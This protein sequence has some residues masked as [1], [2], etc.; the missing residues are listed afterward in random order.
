[1][2]EPKPGPMQ[3][4]RVVDL[5][6]ALSG[7][8]A[9]GIMADQG[10]SVIK[11]EALG[12]GDIG[13]WIGVA[14]GGI[15]AM[16]Q[17]VNRGKRSLAV[18]L[19]TDR[20]QQIVRR[21]A[22]EADVFVQNFRPGVIERLGLSYAEL[23]EANPELIYVSISGFGSEGPYREKSAYDP[24]VQ[25]YGGLAASQSHVETGEPQ[26]IYQVAADKITA[27][28]A[29]Q[30][31]ASALFARERGAGGQHLEVPMLDA[32]VNFVWADAAGNEVLRD[33]DGSQPSSFSHGQRLWRFKDGWGIAA[34]VSDEDF[35]GICRGLGVEGWDAP[36]VKTIAARR[37]NPEA[38]AAMMQKIYLAAESFTTREVME[39]LE[40]EGAPC[41]VVLSPAEL[42]ADPHAKAVGLLVDSEHPVAGPLRQPRPPVRFEKT[43]ARLG[44]PAP[45]L[46]QQTDAILE[47]LG[48]AH[49]IE[50][51]RAGGIVG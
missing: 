39:R 49:E 21:L 35:A 15:S 32:V 44:G 3:G 23:R 29:S 8:W 27:L 16:A 24:V 30:A 36:E 10:A 42:A 6:I 40:A 1:M 18:N 48:L 5:S 4:I 25:A 12:I 43:P 7:P 17:M 9:V 45:T 50:E 51:L 2:S 11:V 14:R 33:S 37:Q 19:K 28:T 34:P 20:G 41:G 22:R 31:I 46:G 47:E 26:L 38:M 13:R